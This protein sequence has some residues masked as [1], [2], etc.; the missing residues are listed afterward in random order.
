MDLIIQYAKKV[1]KSFLVILLSLL[2]VLTGCINTP[3][4]EGD[5]HGELHGRVVEKLTFSDIVDILLIIGFI[6]LCCLLCLAN[7]NDEH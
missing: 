3:H 5:N 6:A 2:L 1:A 4:I 7:D